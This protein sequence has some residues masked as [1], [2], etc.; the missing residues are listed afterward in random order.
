[1]IGWP[2]SCRLIPGGEGSQNP[3]EGRLIRSRAS[4]GY[5]WKRTY[6]N[7]LLRPVLESKR[8]EAEIWLAEDISRVTKP[9]EHDVA[10]GGY[11]FDCF[12]G[13]VQE[14]YNVWLELEWPVAKLRETIRPSIHQNRATDRDAL[15]RDSRTAMV[16]G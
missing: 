13:F 11:V 3:G 14:T 15:W 8:A 6:L 10:L 12:F 1:M 9:E 2:P 4:K 16:A 7:S 5:R